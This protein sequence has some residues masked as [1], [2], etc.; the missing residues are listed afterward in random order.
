MSRTMHPWSWS[1]GIPAKAGTTNG[2][3]TT[4]RRLA[5]GQRLRCTQ[6]REPKTPEVQH[7]LDEIAR[8]VDIGYGRAVDHREV[9]AVPP[10]KTG[11]SGN[12]MRDTRQAYQARRYVPRRWQ[13][14]SAPFRLSEPC[15]R[16][17]ASGGRVSP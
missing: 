13:T 5:R 16:S 6:D 10:P 14:V 3:T 8:G 12:S 17:P 9:R 2:A 1:A 4:L 15:Y 7:E 11:R